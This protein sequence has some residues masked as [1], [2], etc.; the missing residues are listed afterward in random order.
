M[1]SDRRRTMSKKSAEKFIAAVAKDA[2]LR[3]KV[4]EAAENIVKVA[5]AAGFNITCAEIA[6]ALRAYWFEQAAETE[7]KINPF[8][9]FSETPGL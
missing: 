9:V 2:S 8:K 3:K 6:S 1:P 4:N 5:H 7:P